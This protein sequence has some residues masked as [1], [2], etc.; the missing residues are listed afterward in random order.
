MGELTG[1]LG[2][3]LLGAMILGED[4]RHKDRE[5]SDEPSPVQDKHGKDPRDE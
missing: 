2:L 3:R 1:D 5:Y 4:G